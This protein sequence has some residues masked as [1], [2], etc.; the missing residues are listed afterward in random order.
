MRTKLLLTSAILSFGL[1]NVASAADLPARA[2]AYSKAPAIVDVAYDW[3]GFYIGINGGGATSRFDWNADGFGDEGSHNATGGT[4]GGQV[5]Y[6]WQM[7]SVV[8]GLEAQGNWSDFKGSSTSVLFAGQTNT[9][10]IDSFGLFTGQI[11]YAW[12]RVLVYVKGGA[13]VTDN[14][15]TANST[16]PPLIGFDATSETRWG[17][18]VGVGVEYAFAQNWSVGFEYDHLFMGNPDVN[19]STGFLIADHIKEDV[20]LFTAR[21]NYKFGGPVVARY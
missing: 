11:G 21:V 1:I 18:T 15:Y 4:F 16:L 14:H 5:G 7:S 8:F 13:A 10:K 3:S 20:D 6:R 17:A 2:P 9:S 19:S 12:D